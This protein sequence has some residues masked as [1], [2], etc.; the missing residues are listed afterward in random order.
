[1]KRISPCPSTVTPASES[2]VPS[3][4]PYQAKQL[5]HGMSLGHLPSG[6]TKADQL[7]HRQLITAGLIRKEG[8]VFRLTGAGR[9]SLVAYD[10]ANR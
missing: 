1:M 6:V 9:Q 2:N 4:T 3:I 5:R 10:A 7:V 8:E